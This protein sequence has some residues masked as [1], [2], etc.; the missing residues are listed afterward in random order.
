MSEVAPDEFDP[1]VYRAAI[2]RSFSPSMPVTTRDVFAGR[3]AQL[4][5]IMDVVS[6]GGRHAV[7]YGDRGVG[8]TS[9]ARVV[10]DVFTAEGARLNYHA[11][12]YTC[13]SQDTFAS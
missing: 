6:A 11:S 7:V 2:G 12:Y 1:L 4:H 3:T 9:L 10:N 8:K 5:R 13:S